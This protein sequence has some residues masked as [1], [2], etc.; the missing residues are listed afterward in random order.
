M[1]ITGITYLCTSWL[2]QARRGV[3]V[4]DVGGGVSPWAGRYDSKFWGL[5]RRPNG[6]TAGQI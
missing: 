6:A 1:G 3:E 5:P 4:R 2:A